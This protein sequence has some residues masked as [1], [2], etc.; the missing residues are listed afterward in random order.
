MLVRYYPEN[1]AG[2]LFDSLKF[3]EPQNI[4]NIETS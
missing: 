4:Y 2:E 1:G 3:P